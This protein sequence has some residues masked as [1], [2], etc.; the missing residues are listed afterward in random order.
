M[1]NS[2]TAGYAKEEAKEVYE[3]Y[4]LNVIFS[5]TKA[6]GAMI[7]A[8]LSE[9]SVVEFPYFHDNFSSA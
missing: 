8:Q 4:T 7:I 9:K 5:S 3:D 6:L 1:L 2:I